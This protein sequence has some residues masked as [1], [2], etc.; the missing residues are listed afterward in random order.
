MRAMA[1]SYQQL[2]HPHHLAIFDMVVGYVMSNIT[3]HLP[4]HSSS[5]SFSILFVVI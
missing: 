5:P 1:M 3:R 2:V 4:L